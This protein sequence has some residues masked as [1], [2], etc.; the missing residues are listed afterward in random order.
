MTLNSYDQLVFKN[1]FVDSEIYKK[2][3][4]YYGNDV[5]VSFD[6]VHL[7]VFNNLTPRQLL[8]KK[9]V[10]ACS[11]YYLQFLLDIAPKQI[12]DIGCGDNTFKN[13]LPNVTGIDP[14]PFVDPGPDEIASFDQNFILANSEKYECAFSID[15]LHFISLADLGNRILDFSKLIKKQGRG[16]IALNAARM[17]E[18]TSDDEKI[19]LFGSTKVDTTKLSDY[20]DAII[21]DLPLQF[22]VIDNL[23]NHCRN[24]YIDGNLRLVFEK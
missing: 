22:L 10:T 14:Y 3:I 12:F 9:I 2:I 4:S 15:A 23:I 6:P 11:F 13:F 17:V 1:T 5:V 19:S 24:E 18:K 8:S 21:K 16:Y 20:C 7:G